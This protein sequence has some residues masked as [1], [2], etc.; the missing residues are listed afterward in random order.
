MS[1]AARVPIWPGPVFNPLSEKACASVY[2]VC[3]GF[4]LPSLASGEEFARWFAEAGLHIESRRDWTPHVFKT[5]EISR[6]LA[7]RSRVHWLA[8][9]F[10]RK[11]LPFWDHYLA[12]LTAYRTG[13]MKYECWVV[14]KPTTNSS[15]VVR[16]VEPVVAAQ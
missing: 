16:D 2:D 13:A 12:I 7:E 11:R 8:P 6:R 5:W 10:G 14:S 4:G 3:S 15:A 1:D 9:L